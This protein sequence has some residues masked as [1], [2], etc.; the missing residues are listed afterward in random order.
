MSF[1]GRKHGA[2]DN[3]Q[4]I[5]GTCLI[6]QLNSVHR[7]FLPSLGTDRSAGNNSEEMETLLLLNKWK[8]ST[9]WLI[10]TQPVALY[11]LSL[12]SRIYYLLHSSSLLFLLSIY[13]IQGTNQASFSNATRTLT[14]VARNHPSSAGLQ[15]HLGILKLRDEN[16]HS[17]DTP[18]GL[19]QAGVTELLQVELLAT[20]HDF[21]PSS[22]HLLECSFPHNSRV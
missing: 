20:V 11:F 14:S 1:W 4:P 13:S 15:V 7:G 21:C 3:A 6:L 2:L 18:L 8:S 22:R 5:V 12:I 19:A 9:L 10:F 16:C 17:W